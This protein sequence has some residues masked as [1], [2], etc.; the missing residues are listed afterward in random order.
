MGLKLSAFYIENISLPPEVEKALDERTKMGVLGDLSRY[1]QYQTAQ[2]IG[3]AAKNPGG[4]AGMGAG[5]GAGMAVGQQMAGA[6]AGGTASAPPPLPQAAQ[7]F[8]AINGAQAGPFDLNTL[9]TKIRDGQIARNTLVWRH[10]MA[11]WTPAE[12]VTD[13][14]SLFAAVPPP[15]PK[16]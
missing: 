9:A 14:Q 15:L 11:N 2:A 13:L 8:A 7:F 3:D 16:G 12:T 4:I 5:I 6:M 10:G 1:T